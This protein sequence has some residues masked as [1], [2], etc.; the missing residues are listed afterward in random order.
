MK[1]KPEVVGGRPAAVWDA[2]RGHM[3]GACAVGD[4]ISLLLDHR[5]GGWCLCL[6][7]G[8]REGSQGVTTGQRGAALQESPS[9]QSFR[10]H[11]CLL[12]QMRSPGKRVPA[13]GSIRPSRV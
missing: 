8:G 7:E 2:D 10:T 3:L 4:L 5:R 13:V 12:T 6:A 9:I 1:G 11:G